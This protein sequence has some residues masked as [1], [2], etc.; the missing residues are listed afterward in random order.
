LQVQGAVLEQLPG[1]TVDIEDSAGEVCV[2]VR[3]PNAFGVR[4]L[5]ATPVARACA[6]RDI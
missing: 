2:S 6:P 4:A 1:A 3:A 5:L